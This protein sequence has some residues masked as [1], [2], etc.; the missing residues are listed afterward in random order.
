MLSLAFM[1][2][3][4]IALKQKC[5]PLADL[6]DR[7]F[8]HTFDGWDMSIKDMQPG[9]EIKLAR[10][11]FPAGLIGVSGGALI[12]A[13]EDELIASIEKELGCEIDEYRADAS[14]TER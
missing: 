11:G 14:E 12:N 7:T 8:Q 2:C 13:T 5:K 9:V 10:N 3:M 4:S 1:G 6:P